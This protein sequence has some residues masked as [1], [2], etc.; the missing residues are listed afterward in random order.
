MAMTDLLPTDN[1]YGIPA[2][3]ISADACRIPEPVIGWGTVA[4]GRVMLGTY[5]LYV[6]DRDFAA[7]LD[8]PEKLVATECQVACEPNISVLEQTPRWLALYAVG[9]KR[10]VAAHWASAGVKLFVDVCMPA[11]HLDIALLGVPR[12][13]RSYSTRGFDA[14]RHELGRE[15]SLA[16]W[17]C[18][19]VPLFLV[20]GGGRRVAEVCRG[21]P[22]AVYVPTLLGSEQAR[23]VSSGQSRRHEFSEN[24]ASGTLGEATVIE[25]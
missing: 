6:R 8:A 7:L 4:R 11:E 10:T 21:L 2:L 23:N 18:R 5:H 9:R 17:N 20:V 25:R 24:S 3:P 15:Y 16:M 13:W 19:S 14:R 22:G 12:G 1:E